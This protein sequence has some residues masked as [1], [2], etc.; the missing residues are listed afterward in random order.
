M[1]NVNSVYIHIPFCKNIC[2]YCDFCK[3]LYNE[4]FI[5]KYLVALKMKLMINIWEKLLKLFILEEEH[6]LH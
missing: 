6:H 4:E 5:S 2:T 1:S 3:L